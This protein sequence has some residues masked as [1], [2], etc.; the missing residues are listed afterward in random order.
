MSRP[1]QAGTT[2][3]RDRAAL[4][5]IARFRT[6]TRAQIHGFAFAGRAENV[7]KRFVDR[8]VAHGFLGGERLHKSGAQLLWCTPA[9]RDHLVEMGTGAADAFFP[10]R[11]PVAAKDLAH[12]LAIVDAALSCVRRGEAGDEI[13]PAWMLQRVFGGKLS[14]IPDL[15]CL[16]RPRAGGRGTVLAVEVDL[17]GEGVRSVLLPKLT[18][19]ARALPTITPASAAAIL[20]LTSS[21][22]RRDALL[23]GLAT[24]PLRLVVAVDLLVAFTRPPDVQAGCVVA[25]TPC[26]V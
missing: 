11:G 21:A 4:A 19:L 22:R 9:G 13:L 8:M 18:E 7:V 17:G 16:T 23:R 3:P 1:N 25:D 26:D 10:A 15:L 5:L 12:T 14:A 2:L 6:M 20:V 24:A